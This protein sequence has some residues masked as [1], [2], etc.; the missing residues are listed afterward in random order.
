MKVSAD[1]V[2]GEAVKLAATVSEANDATNAASGVVAIGSAVTVPAGGPPAKADVQSP[3][4]APA[5]APEEDEHQ[6]LQDP[7]REPDEDDTQVHL[8]G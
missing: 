8:H 6:Y 4:R 2:V 3:L 7:V 5:G 1:V